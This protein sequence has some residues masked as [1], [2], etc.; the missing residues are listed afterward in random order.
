MKKSLIIEA[1]FESHTI[2]YYWNNLLVLVGIEEQV[3]YAAVD[4]VEGQFV[5]IKGHAVAKKEPENLKVL[6]KTKT[7][8]P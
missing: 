4:H 3:M 7:N 6:Q 5:T 8:P 1:I 2:K